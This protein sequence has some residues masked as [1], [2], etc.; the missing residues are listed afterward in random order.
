MRDAGGDYGME[1]VGEAMVASGLT[2]WR[3]GWEGSSDAESDWVG[4]VDNECNKND[5]FRSSC[6]MRLDIHT[7]VIADEWKAS[8]RKGVSAAIL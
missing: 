1:R 3:V 5:G 4:W 2:Y 7:C 8:T 6:L